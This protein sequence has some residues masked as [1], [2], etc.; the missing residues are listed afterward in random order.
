MLTIITWTLS[1]FDLGAP[2]IDR[3]DLVLGLAV[4]AFKASLVALIF[5]HLNHEKKLVYKFLVFTVVFVVGLFALSFLHYVDPA[6]F[7]G[8]FAA[9]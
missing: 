2:G 7:E 8:F 1:L 3:A 5:M 6:V 4:A 9:Q